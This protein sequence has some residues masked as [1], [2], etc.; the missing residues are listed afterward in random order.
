[1]ALNEKLKSVEDS[2]AKIRTLVPPSE[3]E[4]APAGTGAAHLSDIPPEQRELYS[5]TILFDQGHT[6]NIPAAERFRILRARIEEQ[7]LAGKNQRVI[8]VT[9]A[10]PEE[11]K[12]VVSVNLARALSADPTARVLLVDCDLRRPTV[13]NFFDIERGPGL[14]DAILSKTP[15]KAAICPIK[16]G[17]DVIPAGAAIEDPAYAIEQPV[18]ARFIQELRKYYRYII[19]DCP[20]VLLCSEPIS[21]TNV[22]DG[23]L[24]VVRGWRTDRRLSKDALDILGSGK[25][26]GVVMNDGRDSSRQYRY[27]RYYG[28]NSGYGETT[29]RDYRPK[30]AGLFSFLRR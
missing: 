12:S 20:P 1:M 6:I 14:S 8:A 21:L 18:L 25:I 24:L 28:S 27:Y 16:R 29:V 10:V 3:Q 5:G 15:L 23:T 7:N 17:L 2:N 13:H 4:S 9:S 22:A 26:M 30:K 19:L 11:G